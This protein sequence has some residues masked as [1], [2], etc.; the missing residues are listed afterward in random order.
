MAMIFMLTNDRFGFPAL[1]FPA[2]PIARTPFALRVAAKK[3]P[4]RIAFFCSANPPQVYPDSTIP[5]PVVLESP[6]LRAALPRV[7]RVSRSVPCTGD[8]QRINRRNARFGRSRAS[9]RKRMAIS[10]RF[11]GEPMN[12]RAVWGR[13][14]FLAPQASEVWIIPGQPGAQATSRSTA[15]AI[16]GMIGGKGRSGNRWIWAEYV[17]RSNPGAVRCLP[18]SGVPL[19]NIFRRRVWRTMLDAGRS[20]GRGPSTP[21]DRCK[22]PKDLPR[23]FFGS[24][25]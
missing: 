9:A 16:D 23:L 4:E 22:Q 18:A 25:H 14:G 24:L 5:V 1:F 6:F 8:G 20:A 3:R 7:H 19:I 12:R 15:G 11:Y 10:D 2:R 21:E 17:F 13:D